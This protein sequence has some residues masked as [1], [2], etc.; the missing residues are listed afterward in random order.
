MP[1]KVFQ[2]TH[3]VT[4]GECTVGNH[5]YYAR[6]LDLLEAA[7]GEF[8]RFLEIPFL[9]L[10]KDGTIFP[11]IESHLRHKIS[12]RY[13]DLLTT[14]IWLTRLQGVRINFA[15]CVR[16]Q[17]NGLVLEGETFHA[18][19]GLNEKPKRIPLPLIDRL[20]PYIK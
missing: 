9:Q 7:R 18:S 1:E 13:D 15:Y 11:V 19:S 10:Q 14:E 5:V 4:Y 6:Y 16:N 20:Q 12:A 17:D 8:F 3:R 2:H